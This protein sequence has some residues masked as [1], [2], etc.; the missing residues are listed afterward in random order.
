MWTS[1]N[2]RILI[3]VKIEGWV[4]EILNDFNRRRGGG[5]G[6]RNGNLGWW[7]WQFTI[8][9]NK[10]TVK[11]SISTQ[12]KFL[13]DM[14]EMLIISCSTSSSLLSWRCHKDH[15]LLGKGTVLNV[16]LGVLLSES[17][18]FESLFMVGSWANE[19]HGFH[20]RSVA[21]GTGYQVT[22]V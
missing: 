21:A 17:S 3:I 16:G 2:P 19:I 22:S 18:T 8:Y 12:K 1:R 20:S 10:Y 9:N 5:L 7:G 11:S 13:P 15:W 14:L 6:N 4:K